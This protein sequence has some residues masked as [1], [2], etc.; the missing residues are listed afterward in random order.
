MERICEPEL[1]DDPLQARI[2]AE[3][4]FEDSDRAF[5]THIL[6]LVGGRT[7]GRSIER[8]LDLGCGPGNITFL[9]GESLPHTPVLG[10]DGA[11]A[12]L[13]LA[14]ERQAQAPERW[15]HVHFHQALLPLVAEALAPLPAP[16]APPYDLIVSN[17]LL[18][19]LHDPAVLW[20]TVR[21]LGGPGT[22]VVVR[23]LRRPA[24][25]DALEAMVANHAAS[26][27]PVLR[28]DYANSLAA[29]FLPEEVQAQLAAAQLGTLHVTPQGVQYLDVWGLLP[30]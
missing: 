19:H 30:P 28:R 1:M 4:D 21:A 26:F 2:Y 8:I 25:P 23:D 29:A 16:F 9:L 12:M 18:H 20:N 3:A 22:L 7:S 6:D 15:A 17:S 13:T 27:P 11:G 14:E 24:H 5:T 10:V